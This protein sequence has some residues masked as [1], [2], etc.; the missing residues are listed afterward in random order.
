MSEAF[1]GHQGF[2]SPSTARDD[3]E[4]LANLK[5]AIDSIEKRV[6]GTTPH[7]PQ[8]PYAAAPAAAGPS[9]AELQ[10]QINRLSGQISTAPPTP[11]PGNN[12]QAAIAEIA[13]RQSMLNA[14]KEP[15]PAAA[16]RPDPATYKGME[17][18][19][20]HLGDLKRELAGLKQKV[21]QPEPIRVPQT[22]IDRIAHAIGD[23]QRADTFDETAFQRLT[24]E[25]E[26]LRGVVKNDVQHAVR[27]ELAGTK[28]I[29]EQRLISVNK[30]LDELTEGL[31]AIGR[32]AATDMAPRVDNLAGQLDAMR[33]SIDQ[34]PQKLAVERLEERLGEVAEKL[35]YTMLAVAESIPSPDQAAVVPENIETIER[36]L[37]EISRA[38]VAVSNM[39]A[40]QP[41]IDL[42]AVERVEA[43]MA[44]LARAMDLIIADSSTS[45]AGPELQELTSRIEDLSHQISSFEE[46]AKT[47]DLAVSTAAMGGS[48][49]SIIEEQLRMLNGRFEKAS[50]EAQGVNLTEQ[51]ERL[52]ARIEEAANVNSTAAQMSNLE[53]QIGQILRQMG[54]QD[55]AQISVDLAP[56]EARLGQIESHILNAQSFSLEAA[57][58]AAHQAVSMM[59]PQSE[60]GLLVSAL[61]EDLKALQNIAEHGSAR[62]AESVQAVQE[63]LAQVVDRLASIEDTIDEGV[64]AQGNA[65][66]MHAASHAA[67]VDHHAAQTVQAAHRLE[68][69]ALEESVPIQPAANASGYTAATDADLYGAAGSVTAPPLDPSAHMEA[70]MSHVMSAEENT[71]LEPGSQPPDLDQLVETASAELHERQQTAPVAPP[72]RSSQ[73]NV[74]EAAR[75]AVKHA[76]SEIA[77]A[78]DAEAKTAKPRGEGLKARIAGLRSGPGFEFQKVRKPVVLAAAVVLLALIGLQGYKMLGTGNVEP[79]QIEASVSDDQQALDADDTVFADDTVASDDTMAGESVEMADESTT[80]REITGE[81]TLQTQPVTEGQ[82]ETI[83]DAMED[84]AEADAADEAT[85][86]DEVV[87]ADRGTATD[88]EAPKADDRLPENNPPVVSAPASFDVPDGAGTAALIAAAESGDAKALFQIGMRYSEG[89]GVKRDMKASAKWFG[90]AAEQGFAPAQYSVGSLYEKG[91]GVDRDIDKASMLYEKAAEQGNAR[92]MHNL[93]VIA[94]TGN[95]PS[96]APDMNTAVSWFKQAANLGI[97]DSQFNLGILY[98]QGMGV[99]QNLAESYKWFALAAKTGDSDA[100]SKRD[101]VANAMDPDDLDVA[102]KEVSNWKVGKL[103]EAANRVEVPEEWRGRATNKAPASA[104][105]DQQQLVQKAQA[106]LNER[107]FDVGTPDG[108]IGPQTSK[109]ISEFQR[110][111]G[112]PVTG[113]VDKR[114]LKALDIQV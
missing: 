21:M 52:H 99:P 57:Q 48:D 19:G 66:T 12:M 104:G 113:K 96:T 97:K 80:V 70:A 88:S 76:E 9:L 61:S 62:S 55:P 47:G 58:Q 10:N 102:R 4:R 8:P 107:G 50:V 7:T 87:I 23:L 86:S 44:D 29:E 2:G 112:I 114:L 5:R 15:V 26:Q 28:E 89:N 11:Q 1:S 85:P 43:R 81:G 17:A 92:A 18:I 74:V 20:R 31:D 6:A 53:A 93:A 111:A 67:A 94:A 35:E 95:P 46:Q 49:I 69:A 63:T 14:P 110:S 75:R 45:T 73:A 33:S 13:A 42:S 82:P 101:E 108:V 68:E 64:P 106:M 109:A 51:I 100:A 27:S 90:H 32:H 40:K 72:V 98:G 56:M 77:A 39:G 34:L 36:R 25:I 60:Q 30:R 38:L 79:T 91:I 41:E 71:P 16:P 24:G 3:Q 103:N 78:R 84:V 37:D 65:A 83:Q 22:E 105:L 54:K 59:G